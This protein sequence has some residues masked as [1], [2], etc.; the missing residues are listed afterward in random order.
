V[1]RAKKMMLVVILIA[2]ILT[3]FIYV[4]ANKMIYTNRVSRYLV[5]TEKIPLD[6]IQSVT[7][8]W[9]K[10]LPAF[11]AVVVFKDEPEVEYIYFAHNGVM[12]FGYNLTEEGKQKGIEK[13]ELKHYNKPEE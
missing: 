9:S 4:Q 10:K 5:E 7:G 8:V 1:K 13:S 6:Q 2:V 12:Q 11:C 3:P